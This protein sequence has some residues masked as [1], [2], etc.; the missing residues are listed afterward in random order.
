MP[1][2]FTFHSE[3]PTALYCKKNKI[4]KKFIL[5]YSGQVDLNL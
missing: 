1:K 5:H 3:E 2:A 4:K